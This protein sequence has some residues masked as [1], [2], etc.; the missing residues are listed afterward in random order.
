MV[1][2][3]II[4]LILNSNSIPTVND[5]Q[6]KDLNNMLSSGWYSY[7]AVPSVV[8][9]INCPNDI[10]GT[11]C[12]IT[13]LGANIQIWF[14]VDNSIYFRIKYTAYGWGNWMLIQTK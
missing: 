5:C 8:G 13:K 10:T 3:A 11:L 6:E 7:G 14:S 1:Y 9:L 2:K 12:V 4:I